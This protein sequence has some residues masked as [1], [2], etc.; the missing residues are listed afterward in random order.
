MVLYLSIVLLAELAALPTGHDGAGGAVRGPVGWEL[1]AIVWGTTI[2]LALAHWFASRL[3]T[4]ALRR[5]PLAGWDRLQA[6]S[7]LAGAAFVAAMASVP[8]LLF[9]TSSSSKWCRSCSP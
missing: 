3:P 2:G 5:G 6:L 7:E 4:Q 1:V 9:L 8:V